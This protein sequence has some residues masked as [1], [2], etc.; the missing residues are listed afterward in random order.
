MG[1]VT[2]TWGPVDRSIPRLGGLIQSWCRAGPG[3]ACWQPADELSSGLEIACMARAG[4]WA[5]QGAA[6]VCQSQVPCIL[7][8]WQIRL[9]KVRTLLT[10]RN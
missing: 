8:G 4:R 2:G 7:E 3:G 9:N 5:S 6:D 1:K 10:T